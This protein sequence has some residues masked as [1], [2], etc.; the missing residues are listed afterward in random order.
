MINKRLIGTVSESKK[1]IAGN[2][3]LQWCALVA[4]IAMIG[5]LCRLLE[6]VFMKSAG[7]GDLLLTTV[8]AIAAVA[9][10][11]ACHA[12]AAR[13]GYLS[14]RAVKRTLREMIY[15][16]LLRLGASYRER[17]KTSEVVQVA[18]EGVDQLETTFGAYLPQFFFAMLTPLTL[19]A[20]LCFVN[21]PSAVVLLVC[22]PLIPIAIA[23]VQTWA[24]KLLSK[25]WDQYTALGDTFLENLQGLT[26]LKIYQADGFKN[27]EMNEQSEQFRRITMKVLTMQLNSITIMD[28]VA[29]GGGHPHG[30]DPVPRGPCETGRLP[31]H[32]VAGG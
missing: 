12:G 19:F 26:T 30:G 9:V 18:V 22:V 8:I 14:S 11:F 27:R 20:V 13:M 21:V 28:L 24:K 5:A 4:N 2:V 29:Y 25:Y 16:K 23:A 3:A 32:P 31:R 1:Y 6:R 15:A 7:A 17:V 10:R